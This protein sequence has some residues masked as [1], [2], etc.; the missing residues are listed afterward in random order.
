MRLWIMLT[1]IDI[2]YKNQSS[3]ALAKM[4]CTSGS[5][6]PGVGGNTG[7]GQ[8]LDGLIAF[9]AEVVQ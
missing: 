7:I 1:L 6:M 3:L 9:S 8:G 5:P 4:G 2:D